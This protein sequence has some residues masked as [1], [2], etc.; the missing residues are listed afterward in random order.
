MTPIFNP[1][2]GNIVVDYFQKGGPIMWPILVALLAAIA[3][4]LERGIWWLALARRSHAA[5]LQQST[6]DAITAGGFRAGAQTYRQ[7]E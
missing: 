6:F 5:A 7:R 2:L 1:I 4:V 3:V